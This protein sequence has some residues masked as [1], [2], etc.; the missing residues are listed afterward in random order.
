MT[1]DPVAV[2]G[3]LRAHFDGDLEA[4]AS[5]KGVLRVLTSGRKKKA[6]ESI[7][8]LKAMLKAVHSVRTNTTPRLDLII[9]P[10][11]G[12]T[13]VT[14]RPLVK[15]LL[16]LGLR[17]VHMSGGSWMP[18]QMQYRRRDMGMGVG[19]DHE[20]D[21]WRTEESVVRAVRQAIDTEIAIFLKNEHLE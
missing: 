21:I 13:P 18:G 19:E 15:E 8:E 7:P 17:E 6:P 14:A 12:I 5:M 3:E 9:L 20:W 1:K 10:G 11:S 2:G 16:P 4:I